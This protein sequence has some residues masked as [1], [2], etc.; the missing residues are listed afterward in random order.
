ME[1]VKEHA[2]T[3]MDHLNA[4]VILALFCSLV[5]LVKVVELTDYRCSSDEAI[6]LEPF[7]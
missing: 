3:L 4:P 1:D 5:D 6:L 2:Q 7:S